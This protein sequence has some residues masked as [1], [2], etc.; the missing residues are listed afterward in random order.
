MGMVRSFVKK[1]PAFI[2]FLILTAALIAVAVLAPLITRYSPYEG[3]LSD[4]LKAPSVQHWFGTDRLGRDLFT[5]IIFGARV[6]LGSALLLVGIVVA[7]GTFLGMTAGYFGGVLDAVIMRISDMMMSF[8]GIVFAIAV[9]GI[10]GATTKNAVF[11]IAVVTWPKYARLARGL[12]LKL[13]NREFVDA[14]RVSGSKPF[15]I[16]LRYIFPNAFPAILVTGATDIGAMMLE[17]AALSF[18]GFGA[19]PPVAEWGLMLSEGRAY[20]TSAPWLMIFPGLAIF[21]TVAIFNLTGDKLRDILDP[22]KEQ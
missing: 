19:Q 18:L 21:I 20:I 15:H 6:S 9:A 5:R 8:P 7:A 16:L 13:K 22:G 14:A 17:I 3:E 1:N 12:A 4:A 2:V 10:L 11:A